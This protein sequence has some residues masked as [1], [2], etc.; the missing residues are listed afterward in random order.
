MTKSGMSTKATKKMSDHITI[1]VSIDMNYKSSNEADKGAV[2]KEIDSL[3]KKKDD[4]KTRI[5]IR[6][7]ASELAE[8]A[9]NQ[10]S[11]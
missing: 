10:L 3:C 7:L 5:K 9:F 8:I 1:T 6:N 4:T 2:S 11:D